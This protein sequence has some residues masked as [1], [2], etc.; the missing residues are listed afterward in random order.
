M[1]AVA[2]G[3]EAVEYLQ[4]RGR[5]ADRYRFP[6]P[7]VILMDL[8]MPGMNGFTFLRWVRGQPHLSVIPVIAFTSSPAE[9]DVAEAYESGANCYIVKP[10]SLNRLVQMLATIYG[11]WSR[12]EYPALSAG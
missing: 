1:H 9:A 11:F 10:A 12:C 7:N 3:E 8:K 6:L 4:G 2:G 5:Y